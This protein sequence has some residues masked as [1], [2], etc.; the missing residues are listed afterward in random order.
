MR[1]GA[2]YTGLWSILLISLHA[3]TP[4][5]ATIH[6]RV[7]DQSG[8]GMGG[9]TVTAKNSLTGLQRNADS[10]LTGNVSLPGLPVA[11]KYDIT[12]SKPGFT[13][14][15]LSEVTLAGGPKVRPNCPPNPSDVTEAGGPGAVSKCPPNPIDV[16]DA[17]T[18]LICA[19]AAGK[20]MKADKT[21]IAAAEIICLTKEECS[22]SVSMAPP[23]PGQTTSTN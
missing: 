7:V 9:V 18:P 4:D 16:T 11:G 2:L 8:A 15:Q 21:R 23:L 12:A 22:N 1:L 20:K 19:E 14:A 6:G 10:D 17:G 3:Q 5:T 13:D